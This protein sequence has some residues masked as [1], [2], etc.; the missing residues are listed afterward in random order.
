MSRRAKASSRIRSRPKAGDPPSSD[1][2][3][4][5]LLPGPGTCPLVCNPMSDQKDLLTHQSQGAHHQSGRAEVRHVRGDRRRPGGGPGVFPGRGR[6]RH[7]RQV[8]LGLRHGLQRRDLRQGPALRLAGAPRAHA[9]PRVP[10]ADRAAGGVQRATTPPF[11]SSP[12]PWPPGASRATTRPT[13]GWAS[14]SRPSPRASRATS[15][16]TC[17]CG[18]RR[19]SSSRRPSASSAANLIYG[20]FYYR[21]DP[22]KLIQSLLDNLEPRP[23]RGRHAAVQRARPSRTWTTA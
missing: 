23:D 6:L 1:F 16:C 22:G 7:D 14:G 11:S 15:S 12:T 9:R 2:A 19:T 18:T 13:A 10:A 5:N 3:S 8:D 20:A 21:D 17:G 4:K